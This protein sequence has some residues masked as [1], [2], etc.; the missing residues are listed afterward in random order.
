MTSWMIKDTLFF[1]KEIMLM[2]SETIFDYSD[3][4]LKE[5][6]ENII[7]LK[8]EKKSRPKNTEFDNQLKA[9]VGKSFDDKEFE[10]LNWELEKNLKEKIIGKFIESREWKN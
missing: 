7:Y 5:I 2:N 8:R 10:E 9:I 6:I 4:F 3:E 1:L